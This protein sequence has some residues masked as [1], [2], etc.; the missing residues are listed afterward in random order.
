MIKKIRNK[1]IIGKNFPELESAYTQIQE[2][3]KKCVPANNQTNKNYNQYCN[4][5]D[6]S[7]K[8]K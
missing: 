4:Q 2:L 6:G 7:Q 1:E 5:N 3:Q 8:Q